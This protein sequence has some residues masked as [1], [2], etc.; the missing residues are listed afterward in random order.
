M[1]DL[2]ELIYEAAFVP[3]RWNQVLQR[4]SEQSNSASAQVFFFS[5]DGPPRGTTL[6]N[7]RPLFDEFVK[8][9]FWKFCDS[10]QKMC[11]LQPASFVRVDDFMSAEEI[12]RDPARIMLRQ[13]GI[14][15]HLC[16]AIPMPT[17]ELATFV[18][19]KWIK[20]GGY[21][22]GEIDRLDGLRPHL[23]RASLVAGRLRVERAEATASALSLLGLPAAVLSSNGHVMATNPHL[24]RLDATFLPVAYG[25]LAIANR[26][27]NRLF[28]QAVTDMSRHGNTIGSIPVPPI[29]GQVPLVVHLLPL[30]RAAHDIFGNA[31]ILVVATPVKPSAL[32]PSASL[33]NALFDLTPAEAR[34]AT[35]LAAGLTLAQSAS[36]NGVTVKSARTYLER[37]FQKTGTHQQS[38][39][40]AM[41]K[42]M[43]P[44][45]Q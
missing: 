15:A 20:D 36:R 32:V 41:L 44:L 16:A 38:Q 17:G 42:T 43:Q 18:F 13:F 37:V 23:A 39:L 27:A 9:D 12:E 5:D 3:E 33:L 4:A 10:V 11:S 22:H 35:D 26:D 19:Q 24:D 40:V 8:G 34:L 30:R 1:I 45:V 21:E 14:G 6:D 28:Q 31:D 7:L 25:G 2:I 29:R